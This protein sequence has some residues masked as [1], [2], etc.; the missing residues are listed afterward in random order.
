[1][2]SS[3]LV[4]RLEQHHAVMGYNKWLIH[5][6]CRHEILH[7]TVIYYSFFEEKVYKS[8][9]HAT[10]EPLKLPL[11]AP[12]VHQGLHCLWKNGCVCLGSNNPITLKLS[13]PKTLLQLP[14]FF[15]CL[16]FFLKHEIIV[17]NVYY[18]LLFYHFKLVVCKASSCSDQTII[19]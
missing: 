6:G 5:Y 12:M 16:C 10:S 11:Y 17:I 2:Y 15:V 7:A 3:S 18:L 4:Y 13:I 8:Y 19:P 1:M 9:I 14:H